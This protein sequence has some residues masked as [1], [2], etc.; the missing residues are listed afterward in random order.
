MK[1]IRRHRFCRVLS[2]ALAAI[3]VLGLAPVGLS[4]AEAQ[5][6]RSVVV[7][8]VTAPADSGVPGEAAEAASAALTL[9][10][11]DL[12][13][14]TVSQ[15][16]ANSPSVRRAVS[17]GRIR[18]VDVDSESLDLPT[19]LMIGNALKA[20]FIVLSSIQSF[21]RRDDPATVELILAGQMYE[22]QP[23][24]NPATAEPV[25]DPKVFKAFGVSGVSRP[26]A[27]Y[28]GSNR[29]LIQ[30]AVRDAAR[31]A[32]AALSGQQEI[33]D[34]SSVR[35]PSKSYKWALLALLVAGLAVAVSNSGSSTATGPSPDAYPP[36]NLTS[37]IQDGS[38]RLAWEQPTGTTLSILRYE[39]QRSVDGGA[40]SRV[41][42]GT[43]GPGSTFFNDFNTLTGNH[44]YQYRI[45]VIYTNGEASVWVPS[46]ANVVPR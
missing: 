13:G 38:V 2:L 36:R 46:G 14:M 21:T 28:T 26:R 43:L 40:F 32:S 37:Q 12:P 24:L 29:P 4:S 10:L 19:H 18:Q 31:K 34:I 42:T 16:S 41:D 33:T 9:T 22:V 3:M 27:R 11:N 39:V 15:F 35:K 7:F 45:R 8:N 6:A 5:Q 17:E 44:V 1:D 20:D 23:N 30:E 25:A